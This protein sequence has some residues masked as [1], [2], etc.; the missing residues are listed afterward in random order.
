MNS[1]S[2]VIKYKTLLLLTLF[3]SVFSSAQEVMVGKIN[4]MQGNATLVQNKNEQRQTSTFRL[5][6]QNKV[7]SNKGDCKTVEFSATQAEYDFFFDQIKEVFREKE[8]KTLLLDESVKVVLR[9]I[10]NTDLEFTI[11]QDEDKQ[12]AFSTSATGLHLLF[13]KPWDKQAWGVYLNQ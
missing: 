13:G 7:N 2:K 4:L 1:F 3:A 10:T 9:L 6:Y 11:Y 12:G 8:E 5:K